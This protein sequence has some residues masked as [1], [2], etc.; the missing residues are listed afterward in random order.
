MVSEKM[1]PVNEINRLEKIYIV[2]IEI[3]KRA[4]FDDFSAVL[5]FLARY[6]KKGNSLSVMTRFLYDLVK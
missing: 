6:I 2:P 4:F 5:W 1:T 3:N